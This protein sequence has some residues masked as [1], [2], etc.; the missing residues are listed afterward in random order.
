MPA[1]LGI[2]LGCS[3]GAPIGSAD[4]MA[5]ATAGAPWP[6]QLLQLVQLLQQSS[7]QAGLRKQAKIFCRRLG[8]SQQQS[9]QQLEQHDVV[10]VGLQQVDWQHDVVQVGLQ[11]VGWQQEVVQVGWQQLSQLSQQSHL[12]NRARI[13]CNS[14]GCSQQSS[15]QDVHDEP[16]LLQLLPQQAPLMGADA[17]GAA[18]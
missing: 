18:A 4:L 16:Q 2:S 6:L 11:Q 9:S 1:P 3:L 17:T 12:R 15:Q 7:Q 8:L 14:P 10:Q 5:G 13:R